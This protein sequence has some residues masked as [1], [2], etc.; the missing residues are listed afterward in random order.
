MSEGSPS[1]E[2]AVSCTTGHVRCGEAALGT[3]SDSRPG[4]GEAVGDEYCRWNLEGAIHRR[5]VNGTA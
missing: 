2:K 5:L 1:E 3:D 4:L